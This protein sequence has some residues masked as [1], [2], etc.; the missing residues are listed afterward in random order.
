MPR[1]GSAGLPGS[2]RPGR[3]PQPPL[4][5]CV[6]R[7]VH[8][9]SRGPRDR[10]VAG[11][12]AAAPEVDA[13][14]G[15][16]ESMRV[17]GQH[18]PDLVSSGKTRVQGLA[19]CKRSGPSGCGISSD[20]AYTTRGRSERFGGVLAASDRR[21]APGAQVA[22]RHVYS[23]GRYESREGLSGVPM[24]GAWVRSSA[25]C[26][27][28]LRALSCCIPSRPACAC[29]HGVRRCHPAGAQGGSL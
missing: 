8:D 14:A 29:V 15:S 7:R 9:R 23:D 19:W 27:A 18:R 20:A 26:G 21:S 2:G 22:D 10:S 16:G 4:R 17:R 28:C 12:R 3:I 1:R 11:P 6:V 5:R 25:S 24:R 13:G